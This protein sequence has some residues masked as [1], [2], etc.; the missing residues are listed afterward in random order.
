MNKKLL[1]ASIALIG[2]LSSV[3]AM[4]CQQPKVEN[5]FDY[6]QIGCL[7]EGLAVVKPNGKRYGYMNASGDVIIR[8]QY[9]DAGRFKEGLAPVKLQGKWGYIDKSGSTK[10]EHQF[11]YAGDFESGKANVRKDGEYYKI[12]KNGK[13]IDK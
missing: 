3:S 12:D 9:D 1:L 2:G 4:A 10:I 5:R 7:N 6:G 13:K 8:F 11:D